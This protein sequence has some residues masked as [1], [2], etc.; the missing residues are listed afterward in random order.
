MRGGVLFRFRWARR[1]VRFRRCD[2]A[3]GRPEG[4]EEKRSNETRR[5]ER[6]EKRS[7]DTG[8][9]EREEKRSDEIRRDVTAKR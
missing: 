8:R 4:G 6:E 7:N 3:C 2:R 5:D 1:A 9:D